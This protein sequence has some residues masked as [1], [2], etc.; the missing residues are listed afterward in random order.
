MKSPLIERSPMAAYVIVQI[1]IRDAAEYERYK[2]LAAA[3]VA[4]HGGRYLARGGKTEPLE[5]S[6]QPSRLVVLEFPDAN[7]ARE[8]WASPEYSPAKSIRQA[9]AGTEMLLVEGV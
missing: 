1:A 8:W 2:T 4:A 7:R 9:C 6:W 3:A 5:G